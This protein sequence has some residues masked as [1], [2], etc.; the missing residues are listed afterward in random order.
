MVDDSEEMWGAEDSVTVKLSA[1]VTE[2]SP[3]VETVTDPVVAPAGTLTVSEV[4]LAALTP[5][6]VPLNLTVFEAGVVENP[7]PSIVTVAPTSPLAGVSWTTDK[8]E[9]AWRDIERRFPA[10]SQL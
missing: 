4:A 5:A 6:A 3:G 8:A 2:P 9:E 1:L 10:A 7:V